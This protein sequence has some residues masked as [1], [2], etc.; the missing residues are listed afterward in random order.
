MGLSRAQQRRAS[1]SS[2]D[3][4]KPPMEVRVAAL[5]FNDA[6]TVLALPERL[7]NCIIQT[8]L[9]LAGEHAAHVQFWL[10][11]HEDWAKKGGAS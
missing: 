10:G 7:P 3:Y 9:S 8:C 11:C 5:R 2:S 1:D 4:L 6:S